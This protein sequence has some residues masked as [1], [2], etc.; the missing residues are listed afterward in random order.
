MAV[1]EWEQ[2]FQFI[3]IMTVLQFK[4]G[5]NIATKT[6]DLHKKYF[7]ALYFLKKM[8]FC[9]INHFRKFN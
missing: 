3:E 6:A 8:G 2:K 5:K 9:E 4:L 7:F 1:S